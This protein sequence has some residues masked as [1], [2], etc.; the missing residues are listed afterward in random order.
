VLRILD[1]NLA[2][3]DQELASV[4]FRF[5]RPFDIKRST[6]SSLYRYRRHRPQ[7]NDTTGAET[8]L[9][10]ES[11]GRILACNCPSTKFFVPLWF[12]DYE[13]V[14][15]PASTMSCVSNERAMSVSCD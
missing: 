5:F 12:C 2:S 11:K 4:S 13:P 14:D 8:E 3:K 10:V 1:G 9:P 6:P 7:L 15:A